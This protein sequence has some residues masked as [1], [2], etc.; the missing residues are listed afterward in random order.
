MLTYDRGGGL[1]F[2]HPDMQ[3]DFRNAL[4]GY[5]SFHGPTIPNRLPRNPD[6]VLNILDNYLR[7]RIADGKKIALIIDF[8]ETIA[9]AGDVS[10]MSA[11]DRN[12][13]VILKRWAQNPAFLRAD[14]TICLIAEN[15]IELNLGIVQNPGVASIRDSAARR[16]RAA[17]SSFARNSP[18]LLCPPGPT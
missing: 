14:V 16:G 7:L 8:A 4:S 10:G 1:S 17:A 9:P 18:R 11:E 5:D 2:A 12:A 6:G 3:A 13:L 15:L